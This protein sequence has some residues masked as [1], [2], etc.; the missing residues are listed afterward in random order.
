MTTPTRDKLIADVLARHA[1]Y[2]AAQ[3]SYEDAEAAYF[4]AEEALTLASDAREKAL[5]RLLEHDQGGETP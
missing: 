1:E 5:K 2:F 3:L 4:D